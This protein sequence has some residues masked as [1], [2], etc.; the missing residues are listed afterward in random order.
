MRTPRAFH[1]RAER[2]AALA[3]SHNPAPVMRLSELYTFALGALL[4]GKS[5]EQAIAE[6]RELVLSWRG[7]ARP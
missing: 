3:T 5:D 2:V 1:R 4:E 6:A 7:E